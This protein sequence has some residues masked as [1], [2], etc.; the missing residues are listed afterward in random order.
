MAT[1]G[2][3]LPIITD[4]IPIPCLDLKAQDIMAKNPVCLRS[5]DSVQRIMQVLQSTNHH[6]FPLLDL[7][8]KLVG[9][10]PRNF[11]IVII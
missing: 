4:K 2:K 5:V 11:I 3:Q 1:R 8:D 9:I 6:A 7:K 10:I